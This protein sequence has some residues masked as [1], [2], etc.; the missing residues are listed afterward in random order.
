MINVC[1][2]GTC[3]LWPF[4]LLLLLTQIEPYEY[5]H[6]QWLLTS[7]TLICALSKI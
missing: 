7:I 3:F 5:K 1:L 6:I 2:C 4:V